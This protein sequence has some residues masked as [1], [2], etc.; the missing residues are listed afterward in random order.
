MCLLGVIILLHPVTVKGQAAGKDTI[1]ILFV[2]N[3]LTYVNDLP[4]IV[5]ELAGQDKKTIVYKSFLLPDYA[6]EDHL[7]EGKVQKEIESGSYDFVVAQQGPSAMPE[8]QVMLLNAAKKLAEL[9]TTNKTKLALYMVWPMKA[10]SFDLVNVIQS[11]SNAAKETGA[12]L[13]PAGL[14][15]KHAWQEDADLPLYSADNFH[16]SVTGSVLAALTV[17]GVLAEKTEFDFIRYKD[18]SFKEQVSSEQFKTIK[19]AAVKAIGDRK[20]EL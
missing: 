8:S 9:C 18:C 10:R 16:P 20:P 7:N 17:Y 11:Y 3:S 19:K 1:R 4:A 15:W 14:G 5:K 2:G 12:L 6:I 13:C